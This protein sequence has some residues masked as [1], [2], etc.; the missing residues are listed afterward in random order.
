MTFE[1]AIS[2]S[3]RSFSAAS[4]T[5]FELKLQLLTSANVILNEHADSDRKLTLKRKATE[6]DEQPTY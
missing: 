3:K 5:K 2:D 4:L 6:T 1:Q